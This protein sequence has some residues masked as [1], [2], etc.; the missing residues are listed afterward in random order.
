MFKTKPSTVDGVLS[1]FR[2]AIDD[3]QSVADAHRTKAVQQSAIADAALSAKADA[4]AEAARA[5]KVA[6]QME[7]IFK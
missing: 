5:T 6:T 3:L 2:T 7:A 4:E 1:V